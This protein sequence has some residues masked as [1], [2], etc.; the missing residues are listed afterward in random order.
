MTG[1]VDVL[2]VKLWGDMGASERLYAKRDYMAYNYGD[3]HPLTVAAMAGDLAAF[4][5]AGAHV[6]EMMDVCVV[7]I[8]DAALARCKGGAA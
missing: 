4:K 1:A 6:T 3:R 8:I 5:V 7:G 2:A